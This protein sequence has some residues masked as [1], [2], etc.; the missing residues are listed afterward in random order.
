MY[1]YKHSFLVIFSLVL[2][3]C[4][5]WT[6]VGTFNPNAVLLPL[7]EPQTAAKCQSVSPCD[8][9]NCIL[10]ESGDCRPPQEKCEIK[11]VQN[12]R[13]FSA[14]E[15]VEGDTCVMTNGCTYRESGCCFSN[16]SK[17]SESLPKC[18]IT[19]EKGHVPLCF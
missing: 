9:H 15:K 16:R 12:R 4:V 1:N 2:T 17:L 8:L 18:A 14:K 19:C 11:W 6:N 7:E 13:G 5:D 3:S 10:D